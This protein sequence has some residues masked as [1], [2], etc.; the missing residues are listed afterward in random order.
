MAL[1][2][3]FQKNKQVMDNQDFSRRT[4]GPWTRLSRLTVAAL[5]AGLVSFSTLAQEESDAPAA[6]QPNPQ[7]LLTT[8]QGDILL[9]LFADR[10]P[11]TVENFV[12]YVNDGF[13]DGT[14]FHRVIGN[15][16][17]QGGGYTADFKLKETRDPIVNEASNRI[18]NRRGTIAMARRYEPDSANAQ[19]F[20]NVVDNIALNHTGTNSSQAWGY[21]V[22]G[23]VIDGMDAVEIIRQ[24]PTGAKGPFRSDVPA[25]TVMIEKAQ[26]VDPIT[27]KPLGGSADA[28]N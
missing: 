14:I 7:V 25:E 28:E 1:K 24:V 10:A 27:G 3:S 26:L 11:V 16:M 5:L 12:Q 22:F 20:I 21:A 19:F 6:P 9:E 2:F 4:P 13:Y 17:I 18:S 15:F 8:S 23:Q